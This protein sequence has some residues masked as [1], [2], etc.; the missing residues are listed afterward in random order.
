MSVRVQFLGA[1]D[2]FGAGGRCQT[3]ILV[4]G[5]GRRYLIDC[6]TSS[7]I[8]MRRHGID[9]NTIDAILLTHLHGD[10]FGG[11]PFFILDGVLSSRRER[12]LVVAGPPTSED[13]IKDLAEAL[14]PGMTDIDLRFD[15]D[16]VEMEPEQATEVAGVTVTPHRV[17]HTPATHPTALRVECA[18]RTV[19]YSGDTTWTESLIP[20]AQG[21]DLLIVECYFYD[22]QVPNHM[23]YEMLRPH[24]DELGAK[25]TILTHMSEEM[26]ARADDVP[27]ETS[28][29]GLVVEIP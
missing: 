9:P 18:G 12:P 23:N 5:G 4:E 13:R 11:V 21:A 2:A 27:E 3:C 24:L 17:D 6:G 29:D 22:K 28:A 19:T 25:R 16:I 26:L 14:F 7:L 15:L 1:G 20:A 10:H 8:A